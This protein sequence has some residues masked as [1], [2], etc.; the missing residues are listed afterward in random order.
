MKGSSSLAAT[1]QSHHSDF[2]LRPVSSPTTPR[3]WP[4][5]NCWEHPCYS[6]KVFFFFPHWGVRSTRIVGRGAKSA[7]ATWGVFTGWKESSVLALIL[8]G[9]HCSVG[10][11]R[12]PHSPLPPPPP[13]YPRP[14]GVRHYHL[15]SLAGNLRASMLLDRPQS[16][17]EV[18]AAGD[19]A[20]PLS[21]AIRLRSPRRLQKDFEAAHSSINNLDPN[22][23]TRSS[24][25]R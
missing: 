10:A 17:A 24:P 19:K 12:L 6:D 25:S 20:Q 2:D 3:V 22:I 5:G 8:R 13:A 15:S 7:V 9:S 18:V 16:P 11:H 1:V 23:F 14:G 4:E 21:L